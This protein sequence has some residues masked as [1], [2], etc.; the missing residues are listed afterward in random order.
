MKNL[1]K[2]YHKNRVK[3]ILITMTPKCTLARLAD[4]VA[5][6]PL[7]SYLKYGSFR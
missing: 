1:V 5:V 7:S 3:V 4:T 6:L 2:E